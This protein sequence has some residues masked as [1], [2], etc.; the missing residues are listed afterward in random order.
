MTLARVTLA[1]WLE[2]GP[3][4]EGKEKRGHKG[5]KAASIDTIFENCC[6]NYLLWYLTRCSTQMRF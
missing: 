2:Q 1:E 5:V 4:I 3:I 6:F